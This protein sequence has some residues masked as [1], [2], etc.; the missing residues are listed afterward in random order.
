MLIVI[1]A[2]GSSLYHNDGGKS[3]DVPARALRKCAVNFFISTSAA[4]MQCVP[5]GTSY[6]CIFYSF[7]IILKGIP[8]L[9][10]PICASWELFL[11]FAV[12]A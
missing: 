8:T 5:G 10:C 1:L 3:C 12:L 7:C 2:C 9:H 4:F 6:I 11:L